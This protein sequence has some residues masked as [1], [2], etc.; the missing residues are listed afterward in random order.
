MSV[1]SA[2]MLE[3]WP[4]SLASESKDYRAGVYARS[5]KVKATSEGTR[6]L[7]GWNVPRKTSVL[8]QNGCLILIVHDKLAY[9]GNLVR[10]LS[11]TAVCRQYSSIA[12]IIKELEVRL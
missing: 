8:M 4:I 7:R 12:F 11:K 5:V 9:N 1:V 10:G 2:S 3:V 6:S